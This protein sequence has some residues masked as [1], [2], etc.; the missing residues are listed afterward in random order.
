MAATIATAICG[1]Q[2]HAK[3]SRLKQRGCPGAKSQHD[4]KP[5][6][7][8]PGLLC[9][10]GVPARRK[11]GQNQGNCTGGWQGPSTTQNRNLRSRRSRCRQ[12]PARRKTSNSP[13]VRGLS[14]FLFSCDRRSAVALKAPETDEGRKANH[15]RTFFKEFP[16]SG[17]FSL[18]PLE[19]QRS[20]RISPTYGEISS[21]V[22]GC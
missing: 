21:T 3:L 20:R 13:P 6:P 12:V 16:F 4:V 18:Q 10:P 7:P 1:S 19:A 11:T 17:L 8:G 9:P 2:H 15:I 14:S 22:M 5:R